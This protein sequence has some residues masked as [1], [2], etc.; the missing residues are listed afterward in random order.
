MHKLPEAKQHAG[1]DPSEKKKKRNQIPVKQ[2]WS[3]R[4][5]NEL[6][7]FASPSELSVATGDKRTTLIEV[8]MVR[9]SI[10]YEIYI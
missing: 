3:K 7:S 10:N 5:T 4:C 1:E 9:F 8:L 2:F 6:S